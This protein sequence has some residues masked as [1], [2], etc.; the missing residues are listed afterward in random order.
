MSA[1]DRDMFVL[2][3]KAAGMVQGAAFDWSDDEQCFVRHEPDASG[4]SGPWNPRDD[5]G[6]ALRLAVKM[7]FRVAVGATM[8]HIDKFYDERPICKQT[9]HGGDVIGATRLAI[10]RAAVVMGKLMS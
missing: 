3:A 4:I 10:F 6:D 2:A 8:I 9:I 5:D 1:A 7:G